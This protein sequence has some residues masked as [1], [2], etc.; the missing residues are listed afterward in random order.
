MNDD[1]SVL[2]EQG[3]NNKQP[4][5]QDISGARRE[6]RGYFKKE[7]SPEGLDI[8]FKD[9]DSALKSVNKQQIGRAHV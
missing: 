4:S 3:G 5:Y 2:R 7:L 1:I 6:T 9:L 8:N